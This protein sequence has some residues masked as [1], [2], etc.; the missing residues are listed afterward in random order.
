MLTEGAKGIMEVLHN[1][2]KEPRM[3]LVLNEKEEEEFLNLE[4]EELKSFLL[5]RKEVELE[6]IPVAPLSG[7][8]SRGNVASQKEWF[9]YGEVDLRHLG[10]NGNQLKFF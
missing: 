7:S 1:R 5:K 8:K 9:D 10:I 3:P 6:V 2:T 4:K